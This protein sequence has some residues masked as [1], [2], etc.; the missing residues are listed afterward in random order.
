LKFKIFNR[1]GGPVPDDAI[2]VGANLT[3]YKNDSGAYVVSGYKLL[4]NW[5]EMEVTWNNVSRNET[6]SIPGAND[7]GI[8]RTG[9]LVN[10]TTQKCISYGH[11]YPDSYCINIPDYYHFNSSPD[12]YTNDITPLVSDYDLGEIN[13]GWLFTQPTQTSLKMAS[14]DNSNLSL[15]PKLTINY[16][17]FNPDNVKPSLRLYVNPSVVLNG[18]SQMIYADSYD[19]TD[20]FISYL[21]SNYFQNSSTFSGDPDYNWNITGRKINC[22]Y[23]NNSTYLNCSNNYT[24]TYYYPFY[25]D[26]LYFYLSAIDNYGTETSKSILVTV[27]SSFNTTTIQTTMLLDGTV[28]EAYSDYVYVSGN[29]S[30]ANWSIDSGSLP[31]GLALNSAT[32]KIS[33][34]PTA[35]GIYNFRVKV[36]SGA[37]N[38]YQNLTISVYDEDGE[39]N[40]LGF[41]SEGIIENALNIKSFNGMIEKSIALIT[42]RGNLN[43]FGIILLIVIIFF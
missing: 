5:S 29:S 35:S 28:G 22:T 18:T 20:N 39:L 8:D 11:T 38:V 34:T 43:F 26:T 33:G 40:S 1:E 19:N 24:L 4:K 2:I 14:C 10:F 32:G 21:F 23:L 12:F 15:R 41:G 16:K 6:W 9:E 37:Q 17:R 7:I 36:S 3:Y 42:D 30:T 27:V 25:Y 13:N 31:S